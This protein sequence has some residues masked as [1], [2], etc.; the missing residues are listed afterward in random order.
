M[1]QIIGFMGCLYL[2]VKALEIASN[3]AFTDK[4]GNLKGPAT[5]A[6]ILCGLGSIGFAL[7]LFIQGAAMAEITDIRY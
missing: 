6:L 4:E 7:W 2:F 5:L 1:V 3:D